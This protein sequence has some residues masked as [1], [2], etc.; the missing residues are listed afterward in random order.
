MA[1]FPMAPCPVG[2]PRGGAP[3]PLETDRV[4]R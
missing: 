2:P 1:F 4:L 3:L